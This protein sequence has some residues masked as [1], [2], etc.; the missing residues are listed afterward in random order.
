MSRPTFTVHTL[1]TAPDA[2]R[3]TMAG[4]RRKLGHLPGAVGLM[5]E[6]PELLRGF[7]TAPRPSRPPTSHRSSGRW[8]C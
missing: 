4:V 1:D 5:A 7:L 3:P 8:W 2:A 6:S